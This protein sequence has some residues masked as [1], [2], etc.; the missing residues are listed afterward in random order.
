MILQ[1]ADCHFRILCRDGRRIN[2]RHRC[3]AGLYIGKSDGIRHAARFQ[4]G[5]CMILLK[6]TVMIAV[7]TSF[8]FL[9]IIIMTVLALFHTHD[10][11]RSKKVR[12][13]EPDPDCRIIIHLR[14]LLC[15]VCK[16]DIAHGTEPL[17]RRIRGLEELLH[18][19][20]LD[21][22]PEAIRAK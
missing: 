9:V 22:L 16:D 11:H 7:R 12:S 5:I 18:L 6:C 14:F 21:E 17:L 1:N 13:A 3:S 19:L 15:A 10:F 4:I 8:I 20:F 2:F